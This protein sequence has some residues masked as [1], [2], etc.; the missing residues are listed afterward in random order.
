MKITTPAEYDVWEEEESES[1]G[2]NKEVLSENSPK[3]QRNTSP[4]SLPRT[5]STPFL[6]KQ[7][8]NIVNLT[9]TEPSL[10]ERRVVTSSY[11]I[12]T[13][14]ANQSISTYNG[15]NEK[16]GTPKLQ[17][18]SNVLSKEKRFKKQHLLI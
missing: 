14:T 10:S 5:D 16:R 18:L 12:V 7:A 3:G 4:I 13:K 11:V 9:M 1:S 17:Y 2:I 8:R 6:T 15:V